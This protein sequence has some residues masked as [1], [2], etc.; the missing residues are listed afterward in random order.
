[1]VRRIK[2]ASSALKDRKKK[3]KERRFRSRLQSTTLCTEGFSSFVASA[4]ASIAT[5]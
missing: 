4:T 5:G 3:R 1:M 2:R